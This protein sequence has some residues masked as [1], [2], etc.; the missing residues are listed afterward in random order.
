M[1]YSRV[2]A[3]RIA[4]GVCVQITNYKFIHLYQRSRS[5]DSLRRCA[6]MS[7]QTMDIAISFLIGFWSLSLPTPFC[8]TVIASHIAKSNMAVVVVV[9]DDT[10]AFSFSITCTCTQ[11]TQQNWTPELRSSFPVGGYGVNEKAMLIAKVWKVCCCC[12]KKTKPNGT[13]EARTQWHQNSTVSTLRESMHYSSES[14]PIN[15]IAIALDCLK[16]SGRTWKTLLFFSP[17]TICWRRRNS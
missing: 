8:C 12:Y 9:I 15:R 13:G 2:D 14:K 11:R 3:F 4:T 10:G 5:Y 17:D 6:I 16:R 7:I 1:G